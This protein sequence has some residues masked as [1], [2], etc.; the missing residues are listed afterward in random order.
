MAKLKLLAII[1]MVLVAMLAGV[2]YTPMPEGLEDPFGATVFMA[3]YKVAM[4]F[5]LVVR[6]FLG[7]GRFLDNLEAI[8]DPILGEGDRSPI[9]SWFGGLN[10]T[11][12]TIEGVPVIV[13]KH[14]DADDDKLRPGLIYFHGGG[15]TL[16]SADTYDWTVYELALATG[17][18]AINV[19]YRNAPQHPFP[20]AF[21]DVVSVTRHILRHGKQ[22]GIDVSRVGVAG[23]SAG[24]NLA[25]ATALH[26]SKKF[27]DL[28]ALKYQ[29]LLCSFIQG[30]T[31]HLPSHIDNAETLPSLYTKTVTAFTSLY[32]GLGGRNGE[33][34]G[35]MFLE[36]RHVSPEFRTKS[37][38]AKYVDVQNLPEKYRTAKNAAPTAKE[39]HNETVFQRIKSVLVDPRFSPLMADD[40]TNLPAAIVVVQKYDVLRDDGLLYAKRLRDS[41][42]ETV[43]HEGK[44]FHDDQ[45]KILPDLLRSKT[46][47]KAFKNVCEFILRKTKSN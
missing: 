24:G 41:G 28:P 17:A 23:D 20:A 31:F 37:K 29:A 15:W 45:M 22:F 7:Q 8:Q 33:F 26:L 11:R 27:P 10:V 25:A 3:G 4:S 44:G 5:P 46:G 9:T 14:W 13:Y 18:V 21:D 1:W 12:A 39:S 16:A 42:V 40:L 30:L 32:L 2:L 38:F 35:S 34:H 19:N 36:N 47:L 43:L 6:E